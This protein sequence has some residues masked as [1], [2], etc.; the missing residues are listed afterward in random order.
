MIEYWNGKEWTATN[1]TWRG[2]PV[3]RET[4]EQN[5]EEARRRHPQEEFQLREVTH[6]RA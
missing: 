5:I 1:W 4:A 3:S 6:E 2:L